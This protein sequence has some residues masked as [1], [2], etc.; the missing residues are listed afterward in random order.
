MERGRVFENLLSIVS[1]FWFLLG[2]GGR[3]AGCRMRGV[4]CGVRGAG[5]EVKIIING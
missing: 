2:C 1:L 4:G 3:D 5:C